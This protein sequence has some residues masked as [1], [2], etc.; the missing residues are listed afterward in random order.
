M[1]THPTSPIRPQQ[2]LLLLFTT[3]VEPTY[4]G[5]QLL[6]DRELSHI[7][8]LNSAAKQRGRRRGR[9]RSKRER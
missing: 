1:K 4:P 3:V 9:K 5:N 6:L 7:E 2:I 8:E